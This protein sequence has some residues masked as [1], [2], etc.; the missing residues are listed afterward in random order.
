[1]QLRLHSGTAGGTGTHGLTMPRPLLIG[2][3][4]LATVALTALLVA[5]R[6]G[7]EPAAVTST[8]PADR[9]TLA[10]APTEVVLSFTAAVDPDLSHVSIQDSSGV[11][12]TAGPPRPGRPEQLRQP[13]TGATTGDVTVAYHVTFVDGRQLAGTVRFTV[14]AR[15]ATGPAGAGE[16]PA[17][18][19]HEHGV[20]PLSAALLLLDGIVVLTAVVVLVRR[21][22]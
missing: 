1:V 18:S 19:P 5:Y 13:I 7:T 16:A 14:G 17:L 9:A 6:P 10:R 2:S 22:R 8:D 15:N 21:P 20:D 3:A 12:L 11:F 4:C